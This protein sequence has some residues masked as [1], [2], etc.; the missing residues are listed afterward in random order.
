MMKTMFVQMKVIALLKGNN[1]YV[2]NFLW[3]PFKY[4]LNKIMS[5]C[6]YICAQ[7]K[8]NTFSD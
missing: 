1:E 6:N 3:L 8:L 2:V 7:A 4:F 5:V